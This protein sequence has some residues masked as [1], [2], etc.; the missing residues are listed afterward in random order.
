LEQKLEVLKGREKGFGMG[1]RLW[2]QKLEIL[3]GLEKGLEKGHC[4]KEL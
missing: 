4:W 2:E 3:K 1:Q